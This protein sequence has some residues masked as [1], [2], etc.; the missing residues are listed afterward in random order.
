MVRFREWCRNSLHR[1]SFSFSWHGC[2]ACLKTNA[3]Q[4]GYFKVVQVV[5]GERK[6]NIIVST[7][8]F[9]PWDPKQTAERS[10]I[11]HNLVL[12]SVGYSRFWLVFEG[13]GKLDLTSGL[14]R[15]HGGRS[16]PCM[17]GV[18]TKKNQLR[19]LAKRRWQSKSIRAA[20]W[21]SVA[22]LNMTHT[23]C[24]SGASDRPAY[25]YWRVYNYYTDL[26]GTPR[27]RAH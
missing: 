22:A 8:P 13:V 9:R 15:V 25:N 2:P 23:H 20:L 3:K 14:V 24:G 21:D 5:A 1:T 16:F 12:E 4:N 17:L 27:E 18:L 19:F 26:K 6:D 11:I 10:W 7:L